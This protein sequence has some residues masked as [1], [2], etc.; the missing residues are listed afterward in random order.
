MHQR[1]LL[2]LH[3]VWLLQRRSID[4][5][6][7]A[8]KNNT[9]FVAAD[10]YVIIVAQI[11]GLGMSAT[12]IVCFTAAGVGRHVE[13]VSDKILVFM[14]VSTTSKISAAQVNRESPSRLP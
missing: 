11:L 5:L 6:T 13:F 2:T 7:T 4:V 9:A 1:S 8:E 12:N 14:K 10:D 3:W